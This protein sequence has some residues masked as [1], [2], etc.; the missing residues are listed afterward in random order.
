MRNSRLYSENYE[1]KK[2]SGWDWVH[3]ALDVA[4]LVP[5]V[6]NAADLANAGLYGTR[7]AF[8]DDSDQRNNLYTNAAL[9]STAAIPVV[10]QA[11]TAGKWGRKAY[12]AGSK[13]QGAV[14]GVNKNTSK[15]NNLTNAS[16]SMAGN[17]Q[18]TAHKF[19]RNNAVN[20]GF[21]IAPIGL[22]AVSGLRN[23]EN[24]ATNQNQQQKNQ[25]PNNS[26]NL[27][28]SSTNIGDDYS[29]FSY[30]KNITS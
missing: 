18:S 20:A 17:N 5:V 24:L 1:T 13:V 8:A 22:G 6:G 29:M 26:F 7:G 16:K 15:I 10:G 12:Q 30:K 9:S 25:Q 21:N 23:T 19:W 11:A 2:A 4:G 28:S 14:S 27:N 3:G